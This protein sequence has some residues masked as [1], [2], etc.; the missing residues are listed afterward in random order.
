MKL[1]LSMN[2]AAVIL[3]HNHPSGDVKPS[4]ADQHLTTNLKAS[5]ALVDVR[6]V[7]HIITGGGLSFSMDEAAK[8]K[9][10]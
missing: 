6:V 7:D 5:L 2:A 1:A 3:T 9:Q 4:R 8:P 10:Q